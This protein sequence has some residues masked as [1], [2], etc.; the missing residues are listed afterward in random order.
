MYPHCNMAGSGIL[1]PQHNVPRHQQQ[2]SDSPPMPHPPP[3]RA[4]LGPTVLWMSFVALGHSDQYPTPKS[5]NV[6]RTDYDEDHNNH[7]ELHP[8]H[9]ENQK[10]TPPSKPWPTQP[11]KL[12]TEYSNTLWTAPSAPSCCTRSPFLTTPGNTLGT[13]SPTTP[14]MGAK[15]SLILQSAT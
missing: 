10:S 7:L 2:S 15:G 14:E 13:T 9:V 11:P 1:M 4:L 5:G 8:Q 6:R 3:N 12:S